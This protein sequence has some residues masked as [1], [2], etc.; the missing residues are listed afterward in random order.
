MSVNISTKFIALWAYWV[1][2]L[3]KA[4]SCFVCHLYD[5]NGKKLTMNNY[6]VCVFVFVFFKSF[7]SQFKL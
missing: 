7:Q 5:Y 2:S 1:S 3:Y 4:Q 6:A